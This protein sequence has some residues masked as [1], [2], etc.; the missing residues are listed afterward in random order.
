MGMK[1]LCIEIPL[2]PVV[3]VI[4]K[5]AVSPEKDKPVIMTEIL[6]RRGEEEKRTQEKKRKK[7]IHCEGGMNRETGN[8]ELKPFLFLLNKDGRQVEG[9]VSL[10]ERLDYLE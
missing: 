6:G 2:N 10:F 9:M 1:L 3:G 4:Q 8:T 7:E 5:I